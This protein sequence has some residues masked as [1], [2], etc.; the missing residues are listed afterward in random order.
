MMTD[1][2][3]VK[4]EF[5]LSFFDFI[6]ILEISVGGMYVSYDTDHKLIAT[7][8]ISIIFYSFN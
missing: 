8:C 3:K 2:D 4:K 5:C 6:K 7:F 1:D